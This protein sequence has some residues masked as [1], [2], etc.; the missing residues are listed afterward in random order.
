MSSTT[1]YNVNNSV[2]SSKSK[3]KAN[4]NSSISSLS[5]ITSLP[6]LYTFLMSNDTNKN[7]NGIKL[8]D[9]KYDNGCNQ[10]FG[11]LNCVEMD[12]KEMTQSL[13]VQLA[14]T[15]WIDN[16]NGAIKQS[17]I[18][19][20]LG[21]TQVDGEYK[22]TGKN[23]YN[24]VLLYSKDVPNV[25]PVPM[26]YTDVYVSTFF[27][28]I[29]MTR[30]APMS[31]FANI[32]LSEGHNNTNLTESTLHKTGK[33][34]LYIDV[35]CSKF[36]AV[37]KPEYKGAGVCLLKTLESIYQTTHPV[38]VCRGIKASYD[39]WTRDDIGFKR[40]NGKYVFNILKDEKG[41]IAY[42]RGDTDDN[43]YLMMKEVV[44]SGGKRI[45]KTTKAL[46]SKKHTQKSKVK[47]AVKKQAKN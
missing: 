32:E 29:A 37:N 47:K 3:G 30:T 35:F 27:I 4:A 18:E 33:D 42:F 7:I 34:V 22:K 41:P 8:F 6:E 17:R 21:I 46:S 28:G 43:G 12:P 1:T 31:E 11:V 15:I 44:Q 16:C 2:D 10:N 19:K 23:D 5:S 14:M 24:L 9:G 45:R 40:T 25:S 39:F 26:G 36:D 13:L 38:F 20:N